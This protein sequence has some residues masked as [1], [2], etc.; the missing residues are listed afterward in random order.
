MWFGQCSKIDQPSST[1]QRVN[2]WNVGKGT[3]YSTLLTQ[4]GKISI[5]TSLKTLKSIYSNGTYIF[6]KDKIFKTSKPGNQQKNL[7]ICRVSI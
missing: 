2:A 1:K 6:Y 4:W 7:R 3:L 5:P